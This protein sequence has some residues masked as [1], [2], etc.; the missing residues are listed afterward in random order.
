MKSMKV[1]AY[2]VTIAAVLMMLLNE[3][4]DRK[5]SAKGVLGEFVINYN[6]E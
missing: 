4:S 6:I 3:L 5:I 2:A 1:Y